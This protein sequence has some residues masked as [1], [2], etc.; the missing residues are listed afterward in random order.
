MT[1]KNYKEHKR[2]CY[3]CKHCKTIGDECYD[4]YI[5]TQI[6]DQNNEF[7]EAEWVYKNKE[8]WRRAL[9]LTVSGDYGY[10]DEW[11]EA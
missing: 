8:R 5:R 1:K 11:E 10:C 6:C 2:V 9:D 4:Y 7:E 3:T